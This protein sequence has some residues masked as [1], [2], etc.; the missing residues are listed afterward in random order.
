MAI[1]DETCTTER[2]ERIH[3][4]IERADTLR[5]STA[6]RA[7][8]VVSAD[9][10]L[11]AGI[12]FLL[13]KALSNVGPYNPVE[14]TVLAV[15]IS[16]AV[17]LLVLSLG[18]ATTGIASVWRIKGSA[19]GSSDVPAHPFYNPFD[20]I[21]AFKSF[22]SFEEAFKGIS[23]EQI[24]TCALSELWTIENLYYE[25]YQTLRRAIGLLLCAI[26]SFFVFT[27]VVLVRLLR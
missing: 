24:N 16:I 1:N 19:F 20:T 22:K 12:T 25:R 2:F 6:N 9:A 3:W 10:L 17:I 11:L 4:L 7:A 8:I 15:S 18:F 23:D 21:K 14:R 27:M 5:E 13:D 26:G